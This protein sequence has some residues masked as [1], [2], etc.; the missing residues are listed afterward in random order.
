V[1]LDRLFREIQLRRNFLVRQAALDQRN[2]LLF[3]PRQPKRDSW[4]LWRL[5]KGLSS[6]EIE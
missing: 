6:D 2:Q 5:L 3:A 1:V 4:S